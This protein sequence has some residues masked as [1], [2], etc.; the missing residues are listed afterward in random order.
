VVVLEYGRHASRIR[1]LLLLFNLATLLLHPASNLRFQ[2]ESF[3]TAMWDIEHVR[4]IASSRPATWKGQVEWLRQCIKYLRSVEDQPELQQGIQEFVELKSAK[5]AEAAFDPLYEKLLHYFD[6][7]ND[8][9]PDHSIANLVLLDRD[10]NRSYKNAPFAVKRHRVLSLDRDGVFVPLCTRNVFLKCYNA[11]VDHVM[12]WTVADRDGYL[13]A[14]SDMLHR[15]FTG[16]WIY[17]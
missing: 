14:I 1:T 11:R 6:E 10:T 16:E 7:A 13:E 17:A 12:F 8:G 4:S 3:K 15:F 2:F 5:E 9:E